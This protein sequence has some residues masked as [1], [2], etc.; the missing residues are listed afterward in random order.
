M[1]NFSNMLIIWYILIFPFLKFEVWFLF[2]YKGN[3]ANLKKIPTDLVRNPEAL[4]EE[5]VMA[6]SQIYQSRDEGPPIQ[7]SRCPSFQTKSFV[8]TWGTYF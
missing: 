8:C 5:F 6:Q 7:L 4:W 3:K 2:V 1:P